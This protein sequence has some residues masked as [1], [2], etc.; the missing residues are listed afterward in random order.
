MNPKLTSESEVSTNP[1]HNSSNKEYAEEPSTN[2]K[3][4]QSLDLDQADKQQK[5]TKS[6]AQN[7]QLHKR[8]LYSRRKSRIHKL[9]NP[10]TFNNR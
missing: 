5:N 7:K 6:T 4:S 8:H 9:R 2:Q 1:E 3:Y 10:Y